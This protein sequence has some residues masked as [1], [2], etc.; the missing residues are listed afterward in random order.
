MLKY[1]NLRIVPTFHN[2]LD[3]VHELRSIF[4][5]DPPDFLAVEFPQNLQT[6]ILQGVKRLPKISMILYYDELLDQQLYIPILPSDSLIEAIRLGREYGIPVEFI[7]LFVKAYQ[8]VLK[9][10][11][12]TYIL[13]YLDLNEYYN[14]LNRELKLEQSSMNNYIKKRSSEKLKERMARYEEDLLESEGRKIKGLENNGKNWIHLASEIDDLRNQYMAARLAQLMKSNPE[15]IILV[16][17]G[18]AHWESIKILLK[19][20]TYNLEISALETRIDAKI[21]NVKEEDLEKINIITPNINYQFDQFRSK[22]KK[23]L[24]GLSS[25]KFNKIRIQKFDQFHAIQLIFKNAIY[26]YQKEYDE[27]ITPHKIKSIIQYTRNIALIDGIVRPQYFQIVLA[28]KSIVNDDFAWIV[29]EECKKYPPARENTDDLEDIQLTNE[30]I[31]LN[32]K[33]FTIRRH[34]PYHVNKIK[35]PLKPKPKESHPGEWREYWNQNRLALVS[36]LPEDLFEENYFQHIRSK[37]LRLL[38]ENYVRVHKFESTLLDGIDFRETIRNWA[39]NHDIYVREET[40]IKGKVDAVV[41]I[42]DRDENKDPKYPY[43]MV[44]YA[45]HEEESDLGFYST[46]PGL[47]LVGPGISRIEL[48]GVVSFFPPRGIPDIWT[49]KF[50]QRYPMAKRKADVLLMAAL[51]YSQKSFVTYVSHQKPKEIFYQIAR[52]LGI[53]I[54]YVSIDHF[55]PISLRALRNL[56]VL[57]GKKTRK[58]AHKYIRKRKS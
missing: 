30:G 56:H 19:S 16:V 53:Q 22:Q 36:Y 1:K 24:D 28:S 50:S 34:I 52:L 48:G 54:L 49:E 40:S 32:G 55:N 13:D 11:P 20:E 43:E 58:F 10:M 38:Q 41:I 4:Y 2:N 57:A 23:I 15:S 27:V 9:Q 31:L 37:T 35:L 17:I 42:F 44:W 14:L 6:L 39:F 51:I 5:K 47:D 12:D 25:Q 26:K 33:Y 29:W 8:P 45:E 21:F 3:F 46:F 7:D 18:L